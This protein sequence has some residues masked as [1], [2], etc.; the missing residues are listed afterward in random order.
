MPKVTQPGLGHSPE[1]YLKVTVIHLHEIV[2]GFL[3]AKAL[4]L[5]Y[6]GRPRRAAQAGPP[7]D[8]VH[9]VLLKHSH[10]HSFAHCLGL[11]SHGNGP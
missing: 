5:S 3:K 7:P 11:L 4:P 1:P 8:V 6:E 10:A 9:K 2:Q